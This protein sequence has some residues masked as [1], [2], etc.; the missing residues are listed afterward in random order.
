MGAVVVAEDM[1][2]IREAEAEAAASEQRLRLAHEAA[3]LGSWHWDMGTGITVW[4]EQLE[5]IYGLPPG[6]FDGTF[7]AWLATVHP[8]DREHALSVVQQ[9]IEARSAYVLRNR[10][11]WP[12]GTMRWIEA[13]GKV[14]TDEHGVPYW[15]HRLRPRHHRPRAG[16]GARGGRGG[17]RPAA[18]AGDG[19]LRARVDP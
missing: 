9:A 14:T 11:F 16:P 6:G 2:E 18:P 19:R 10:M 15:D 3:E 17:P 13:H 7:E 4:D 12:D 1:T 5:A 8:D